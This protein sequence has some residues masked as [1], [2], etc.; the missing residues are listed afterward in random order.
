MHVRCYAT[1]RGSP[2]LALAF[3]GPDVVLHVRLA[4]SAENWHAVVIAAPT[5]EFGKLPLPAATWAQQE[6]GCV[7]MTLLR[8]SGCP[9]TKLVG[10]RLGVRLQNIPHASVRGPPSPAAAASGPQALPSERAATPAAAKAEA[11]DGR[12]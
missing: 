4:T 7:S 8:Y 2:T 6:R 9:Y 3:S 1:R 12:I 11:T 10:R 5:A